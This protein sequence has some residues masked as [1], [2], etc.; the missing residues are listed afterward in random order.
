MNSLSSK[1][2]LFVNIFS[3][4][5][6]FAVNIGINFILSPFIVKHMGVEANGFITLANNF[7]TYAT[8]ITCAV[9]S[10]ASRF[11]SLEYHKGDIEKS[12]GYFTSVFVGNF[13]LSIFFSVFA[14]FLI[15][16]IENFLDIPP[17]LITDVKIL[18]TFIFFNFIIGTVFPN[19]GTCFY[20]TN[21]LYIQSAISIL[22]NFLRVIL[23]VFLFTTFKTRMYYVAIVATALTLI[24]QIFNAAFKRKLLPDVKIKKAYFCWKNLIELVSSGIW[25]S[26]SQLG[27]M[28]LSGLDVLIANLFLGATAMG[29][30]SIVKVI[31][32]TISSLA[33]SIS[34][35]FSPD[36]VILYAKNDKDSM[37]KELKFGMRLTT[38]FLTAILAGLIVFGA[39]FFALWQPTQ[40]S[41]LL[42]RLSIISCLAYIIS[43]SL[44]CLY[45]VFAV[46]NKVKVNSIVLILS[47]AISTLAVFLLLKFTDLGIYAI[48]GVSSVVNIIKHLVYTIPYCAKILDLKWTT[49]Y[50]ETFKSIGIFIV[51]IILG[52]SISLVFKINTF[53]DFIFVCLICG[54]ICLVANIYLLL[55]RQQRK[56]LINKIIKR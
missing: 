31:P 51:D 29:L 55:N 11:I 6:V 53:L 28:L 44:Q 7:V 35:V 18:F 13:I 25:N 23:L 33:S 17:H 9:N 21:K 46:V 4:L 38:T 49:F 8:V 22:M 16:N 10:M 26:I 36:L 32:N 54:G 14:V 42:H 30:V 41:V 20:T 52:Y 39:D 27:V 5:F 12:S 43:N 40:D 48:V 34:N 2:L 50:P 3:S 45:N 24:S 15:I 37:I 56:I 19:W 1:K 47:G